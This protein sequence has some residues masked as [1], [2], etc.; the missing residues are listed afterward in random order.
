MNKVN[1]LRVSGIVITALYLMLS[2]K[3]N[4]AGC[5][6]VCIYKD[7]S[8]TNQSPLVDTLYKSPGQTAAIYAKYNGACKIV[9]SNLNLIWYLNGAPYDTTAPSDAVFDGIWTYTTMLPV[10][11]PGTYEVY[12][13]DYA[14]MA[15]YSCGKIVVIESNTTTT[16][17]KNNESHFNLTI[18]PNP[19]SDGRF[20]VNE[21]SGVERSTIQV[22]NSLGELINLVP[23]EYNGKTELS[24]AG[25]SAGLYVVKISNGGET[26]SK[27]ILYYPGS[28]R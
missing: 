26:M 22:F 14:G 18:F 23:S 5:T 21:F 3:A 6:G 2:Q 16:V 11:T 19:T 13:H 8:T 27:K 24:L 20:L 10:T 25:H 15:N 1:F 17:K 12:F 7:S 9:V 28:G 4:A